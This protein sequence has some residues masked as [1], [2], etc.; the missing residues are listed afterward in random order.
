MD[1]ALFDNTR[2]TG[3]F[4][5]LNIYWRSVIFWS[6]KS[7]FSSGEPYRRNI[8]LLSSKGNSWSWVQ[9]NTYHIDHIGCSYYN[10]FQ[11]LTAREMDEAL[12]DITRNTGPSPSFNIYWRSVI[13]W[14]SKSKFCSG[15]PYRR[16]ILLLSSKGN[17]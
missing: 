7:K 2:N 3:P 10:N 14:N 12:F 13:F 11:S 16:N 17:S 5:S 9:I 8:L 6:S 4:P 1:D 15:E